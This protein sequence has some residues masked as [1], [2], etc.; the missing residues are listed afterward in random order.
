[1][2]K[3]FKIKKKGFGLVT[4]IVAV[5]LFLVNHFSP[6]IQEKK[7]DPSLEKGD[8]IVKVLD[9]GQG[10]AILIRSGQKV[11][12][13]DSGDISTKYKLKELLEKNDVQK[14][15][16]LIATHPHSDHIGGMD[17]VLKNFKVDKIIDS[18]QVHTSKT[19]SDYLKQVEKKKIVFE[20]AVKG[21]KYFLDNGA[22]LEV[23]WPKEALLQSGKN[24]LNN[25]S[26]VLRLA[27]DDFSMLLTGDIEKQAEAILVSEEKVK[28]NST[29]LKSPHHSSNGSSSKVFLKA[30]NSEAVIISCGVNNDYGYPNQ[31]VLKRYK[32]E[33]MSTYITSEQGT[34]TIQTDGKNYNIITER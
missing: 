23:L 24:A 27:K 20:K 18:G 3:K 10:D 13:V 1:M 29:I 19:F 7:L 21:K 8:L 25:N 9:I 17:V 5:V 12:L 26:I 31:K 4:L 15:D 22:Y 11:V 33:G 6:N 2:N 30:V 28:L 14:I 34:I 32:D 16:L